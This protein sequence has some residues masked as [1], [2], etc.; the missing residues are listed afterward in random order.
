[1]SDSLGMY[2]GSLLV[3]RRP[4]ELSFNV[5]RRCHYCFAAA[6]KPNRTVDVTQ[7][8]N[9]LANYQ[10][11]NTLAAKLLQQ[12]YVTCISNHT[13]PLDNG[14][15]AQAMPI[16]EMMV[17]LELPIAIQTK[18]ALKQSQ[19]DRLLQAVAPQAPVSFYVTIEI[20]D[21]DIARRVAPGAPS[22]K[23]R[24]EQVEAIVN[25]GH[26]ATVGINPTCPEWLPGDD[27][28]KLVEAIA[29]AGAT[30]IWVEPLHFQTNQLRNISPK[31]IESM[32]RET[33]QRV[34]V[35]ASSKRRV[36]DMELF[37]RVREMGWNA[38]LELMSVGNWTYSEFFDTDF[39]CYPR[40][41]PVMQDFVNWC[42][43]NRDRGELVTFEDFLDVIL[44]QLPKGVLGIGHHIASTTMHLWKG[45]G[46]DSLQNR[47]TYKTLLEYVWKH[48]EIKC[49]PMR[50][51]CFGRAALRNADDTINPI[52]D[53][54]GLPLLAFTPDE[55]QENEWFIFPDNVDSSPGEL[56]PY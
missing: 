6:N 22:P 25:A 34:T 7:I 5:C 56:R 19:L 32:G 51:P 36:C 8:M 9:L 17:S 38:G 13:D 27:S 31:A 41:Y 18:G 2:W 47:M 39:D 40:T 23:Q 42:Y 3:D 12:K 48:K 1:M 49:S 54:N 15:F 53:D 16:I 14:S 26:T 10:N 11:R 55:I 44:P 50:V 20:W 29:Y 46:K 43:E 24:L 45:Q 30:G 21:E 37:D 28:Q 4:L 52:V 33:V 35:P